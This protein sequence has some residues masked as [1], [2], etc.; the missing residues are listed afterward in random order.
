MEKHERILEKLNTMIRE[1]E[2]Q[3][4][5]DNLQELKDYLES[6]IKENKEDIPDKYKCCHHTYI[7]K[8]YTHCLICGARFDRSKIGSDDSH[9]AIDKIRS[10]VEANKA[11]LNPPNMHIIFEEDSDKLINISAY[12]LYYLDKYEALY[13]DICIR[14]FLIR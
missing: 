11:L 6:V 2:F 1:A 7:G 12:L 14:Y 13:D 10:T 9:K 8:K 4:D 5:K 3:A